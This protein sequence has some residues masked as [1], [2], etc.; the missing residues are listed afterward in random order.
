MKNAFIILSGGPSIYDPKDPDKHDQSWDNFVTAPL[1]RSRLKP[2]GE[3]LLVHDPKTEDVHWLVYEPAYKDRWTSD[4]ANKTSAPTQYEHAVIVMKKGMLNYL[5]LLKSRA[6]E[7]G[8]KYEGLSTAQGFWNYINKLKSTKV[9]RVWFYGHASDDLWL[10][11]NHDPSDHAAVSPDSDAI[12]T[13]A[14]IKKIAAFSFVPQKNADHPH[15]FFGCNTKAFAEK[16]AN[17]LSVF[18]LGSSDKVDFKFI[19]ANGGMV[20]LSAGAKWYQCSKASAP[21]QIPLKAGEA[22]P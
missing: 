6:K 22:V 2:N 7:R 11:L 14:D 8:W 16:W 18:A 17:A 9:S 10:S 4:L 21:K 15:K 20:T 12:L 1:L 3:R 13:R 19:H 5:D